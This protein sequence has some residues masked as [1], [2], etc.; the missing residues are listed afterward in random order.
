[1]YVKTTSEKLSGPSVWWD[2]ATN[3]EPKTAPPERAALTTPTQSLQP[4]LDEI[5]NQVPNSIG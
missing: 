2:L 1:M 3:Q 4:V 5:Q